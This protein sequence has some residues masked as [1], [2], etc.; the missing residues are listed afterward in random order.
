MMNACRYVAQDLNKNLGES[1]VLRFS[2]IC[3]DNRWLLVLLLQGKLEAIV[4]EL[5]ESLRYQSINAN[6]IFFHETYFCFK[7]IL[8]H[9]VLIL[10]Y[11]HKF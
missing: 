1:K 10:L 8:T 3:L 6:D 11:N 7:I 5:N 2:Q 4:E 9:I